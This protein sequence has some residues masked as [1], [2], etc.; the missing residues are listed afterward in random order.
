MAEI[1]PDD[2]FKRVDDMDNPDWVAEKFISALEKSVPL[3]D[4]L[5]ERIKITLADDP[6]AR[7]SV[8]TILVEIDKEYTKTRYRQLWIFVAGIVS[9]AITTVVLELIRRLLFGTT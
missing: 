1:D 6:H 7:K 9:L 3:R 2:Y 5:I 8:K 4:A